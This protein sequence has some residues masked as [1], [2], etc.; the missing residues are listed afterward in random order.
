[1]IWENRSLLSC[2]F[3]VFWAF[4][5]FSWCYVGVS[6]KHSV[7]WNQSVPSSLPPARQSSI[8]HACIYD[9]LF[10]TSAIDELPVTSVEFYQKIDPGVERNFFRRSFSDPIGGDMER[11][12][13]DYTVSSLLADGK[14][15][16]L[17]LHHELDSISEVQ[18]SLREESN[19]IREEVLFSAIANLT[20]ITNARTF[21]AINSSAPTNTSVNPTTNTTLS[22]SLKFHVIYEFN[23][24]CMTSGE[25]VRPSAQGT[26]G[27]S[28]TC[29]FADVLTIKKELLV[30][31]LVAEATH[32][33]SLAFTSIPVQS[34]IV[35]SDACN[36]LLL[37]G[38][39]TEKGNVSTA[40]NASSSSSLTIKD[41]DFVLFVTASPLLQAAQTIAWGKPCVREGV[42]IGSRPVIGQINFIPA[43]LSP[44]GHVI[45][46]T[47]VTTMH[48][49]SHALGFINL[50]ST[51]SSYVD[52]NGV[53][54]STGGTTT[55]YREGLQKEVQVVQTPRVLQAAREH[56][57]CAT[58]DGVEIE[59]MG[60]AGTA[61][62]HWKKR[63]FY[64]EALVG[65]VSSA[66]LFYS[67]LT[68][69]FF[70]DA[71]FYRARYSYAADDYR[72]GYQRGCSFATQNCRFLFD[73]GIGDE[74]CFDYSSSSVC[75]YDKHSVG[76]CDT[77]TYLSPLPVQY[78]YYSDAP[79]KGGSMSTMDYCPT[80]IYYDNA[81]C[82]N[83]FN[84]PLV[85]IYGTEFGEASRCFESTVITHSLP[86]IG[87]KP[88]CFRTSC[89]TA[90]TPST[91]SVMSEERPVVSAQGVPLASS[92]SVFPQQIILHV[93][94]Q[95]IP[96]PI[97]GDEGNADTSG[98]RGLHGSVKC[99][100]A[101]E[102]CSF[103]RI[104]DIFD[105]SH[106]LYSH[107]SNPG[108]MKSSNKTNEPPSW[109]RNGF[110]NLE[111]ALSPSFFLTKWWGDGFNELLHSKFLSCSQQIEQCL[112]VFPKYV[113]EESG[114]EV[115]HHGAALCGAM[116]KR[117]K[118]CVPIQCLGT[119]K[120]WAAE[121][122]GLR[123][124]AKSQACWSDILRITQHCADGWQGANALCRLM[125]LE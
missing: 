46:Q 19:T 16:K 69:S 77:M 114:K 47:I 66:S 65:V 52:L 118:R 115:K 4:A 60:G 106:T 116:V 39:A 100:P 94:G 70:E 86:Q 82:V 121:R 63:L 55:V 64:Q 58:L 30:R 125:E 124:V 24:S 22:R 2:F 32:R 28:I 35:P 44:Q 6:A 84:A 42:T 91:S 38:S 76:A 113:K 23:S 74:F 122:F 51:L 89:V 95:T 12:G 37:L 18:N 1:M 31:Q 93:Q 26:S 61:G 3:F 107:A 62:S 104:P 103:L 120:N 123:Y 75:T 11:Q 83:P 110:T 7:L 40:M 73:E 10:S 43:R 87:S 25:T 72:W 59:D 21:E 92:L 14:K 109:N 90:H 17:D 71:G 88:H 67:S 102:I 36:G 119:V 56:F 112:P 13:S 49:I 68:L 41:S 96:C 5:S 108:S 15:E 97:N 29:S 79:N 50:F 78:Q 45:D 53:R 98:L 85:N 54:Q 8:Y 34:I 117:I 48:E 105:S 20:S 80:V 81:D 57:G 27:E 101:T 99:P 9:K 33:L 111:M